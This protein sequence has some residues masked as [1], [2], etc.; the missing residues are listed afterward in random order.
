MSKNKKIAIV[1]AN[2]GNFEKVTSVELNSVPQT[3]PCSFFNFNESKFPLRHCSFTP[4]MQ[5]RLVKMFYWQMLPDYDYYIWIDSSCVFS[6]ADSVEWFIK[7]CEGVDLVV[8]KHPNRKT[9]REEYD[10]VIER[11]KNK[12]K[13]L[14]PRYE[15]EL[16]KE[17]MQEIDDDKDYVDDLLIASTV[18]VC[19][20]CDNIKKLMKEWWYHNSRYTSEEQ[21]S[22]PYAIWKTRC[23]YKALEDNYM[24]MPYLEFIRNK[25]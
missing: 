5:A 20:N 14:T 21:L 1:S 8:F 11:L 4:R 9:I 24:K 6:R 10:Y 15:N 13:Y 16:F 23:T 3:T 22:L 12:C 7:Q 17:Q 25:K 18:M 19:K 2:F